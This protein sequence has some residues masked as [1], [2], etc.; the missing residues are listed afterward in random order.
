[1]IDEKQI[2]GEK[3]FRVVFV[4]N[5]SHKK[6][7]Q[8]LLMAF[9]AIHKYDPRYTFHMFGR[10]DEVRASVFMDHFIPEVGLRDNI[11]YYGH[12]NNLDEF[13]P[14]YTFCLIS[15][16]LEGSPVGLL[17]CMAH[18]IH[19]LIFSFVGSREQYPNEYIWNNFDELIEIIKQ[20]P[21]DPEE[22]KQFVRENYSLTKQLSAIDK[23][24]EDLLAKPQK[25]IIKPKEKSISCILAVKN[26]SATIEKAINSLL[27]QSRKLSKIVVVDDGST[28]DTVKI[29]NQFSLKSDSN[30]PIEVISISPSKWVFSAR[31]EGSKHIDDADGYFFFLDH[32]DL[33]SPSFVED[34]SKVLDDNPNCDV[35]YPDL[36][37]FNNTDKEQ[38]FQVPEFDPQILATRNFI[39]Y[40]SMQR[41]AKFKTMGGYSE[42]LND[43]RNHLTEWELW[44]R[45]LKSGSQFKHL[46]K[47]LFHYFKSGQADQMS[48][49]YETSRES[50]H[51]QMATTIM[52]GSNDIQMSEDKER[53]L[54]VCQGKDYCDRNAVGFELYTWAKP[55]EMDGR[56]EVYLFQYDVEAQY[57]GTEIMQHKLK[58]MAQLI[59]PKYIFHPIY[60]DDISIDTW[61]DIS[62]DWDTICWN[63]DEW[64]QDSFGIEYQKSFRYTVTTY[65]SVFE[66]MDHPGKILS[67]WAVN[68]HYFYPRDKDIDVSFCGQSHTNRKE[69]L[70]G[71]A[72]ECYGAGWPN[73]FISFSEMASVLGRSKISISFSMGVEGR[74]LKLRPFEITGSNTLCICE[75]MP[76]IENYFIPGKEIVLFD[77][78]EEMN[79]LIA[80]YLAHDTERKEIA[81]AGYDRVMKEHT[82]QDR[83]ET[84]FKT[85]IQ[86]Y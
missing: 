76:G 65:P 26:G 72:I 62:K 69:L 73:G 79:E 13:L 36:V 81:Q 54:L 85:I 6:G 84:I 58:E 68:K 11:Q 50:Q 74:Q 38:I 10:I 53:I 30:V 5:I 51:L 27:K 61:K 3:E 35:V 63:S 29:V 25:K 49:N 78:K 59:K 4:G 17:Q 55:L 15:S 24:I 57:F 86:G 40:C 47:A 18:G 22:I 52:G 37:Y 48:G 66:Q 82:W 56:F 75:N 21:K 20:G 33:V 45:Y 7:Y 60:R 2:I 28:D 44:L 64:R 34:M 1:M 42:Y 19:P 67:Q 14:L 8:L 77:T 32:D 43:S 46:P 80:Y 39:A 83:F 9:D 23:I 70:K 12:V 16:P 71:S 41:T 31:N